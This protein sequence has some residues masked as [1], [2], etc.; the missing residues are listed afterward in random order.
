[1][2]QRETTRASAVQHLY[3]NYTG[4]TQRNTPET[5]NI[6][7]KTDRDIQNFRRN[8]S[9]RVKLSKNNNES[10]TELKIIKNLVS[11]T[12]RNDNGQNVHRRPNNNSFELNIKSG[13]NY[14]LPKYTIYNNIIKKKY[15]RDVPVNIVITKMLIQDLPAKKEN[16]H[17]MKPDIRKNISPVLPQTKRHVTIDRNKTNYRDGVIDIVKAPIIESINIDYAQQPSSY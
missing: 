15:N 17:N 3:F 5:S 14:E 1:M 10:K 12:S 2:P 13:T 6:N 9:H 16:I 11:I 4:E 8:N 7:D